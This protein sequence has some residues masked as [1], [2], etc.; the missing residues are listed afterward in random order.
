MWLLNPLSVLTYAA[1]TL[2]V[3]HNTAIAAALYL[4]VVGASPNA[5]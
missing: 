4:G 2:T 1:Q 3:V 5:L